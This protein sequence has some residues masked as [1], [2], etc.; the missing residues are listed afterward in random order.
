[1]ILEPLFFPPDGVCRR[2]DLC[3]LPL[4]ARL[5][6]FFAFLCEKCGRTIDRNN[7]LGYNIKE[8]PVGVLSTQKKGM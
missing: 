4:W 8:Y 6:T 7:F 1:M 3:L 2:A 5:L